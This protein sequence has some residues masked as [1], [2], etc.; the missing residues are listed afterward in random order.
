MAESVAWGRIVVRGPHGQELVSRTLEG[1]HRPDL[2]VVDIIARLAVSARR[3][4]CSIQVRDLSRDLAELLW[5]AGLLSSLDGEV[6]GEPEGG[7]EPGFEVGEEGML[8]GDP[9]A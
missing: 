1:P 5:L 8:P 3:L 7:E 6:G 2:G 4:G 9:V